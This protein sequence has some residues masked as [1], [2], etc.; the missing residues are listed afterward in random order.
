MSN[1]NLTPAAA[2]V[3]AAL[4]GSLSAIDIATADE[5]PF[6]AGQL[7]SGYLQLASDDGEG[8]C[9]EGKCGEG[10]DMGDDGGDSADGDATEGKCGGAS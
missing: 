7:D 10:M 4:A 3:G 2:I 9:G 5:N 1:K 6:G 8:K